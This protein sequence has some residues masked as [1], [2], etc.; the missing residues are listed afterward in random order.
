MLDKEFT[1]V[2]NVENISLNHYDFFGKFYT[3]ITNLKI[4][5]KHEEQKN[6]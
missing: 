4:Y 5:F 6:F 1:N 2:F 3:Q